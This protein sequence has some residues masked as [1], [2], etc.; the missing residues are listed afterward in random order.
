MKN[1]A[2][3]QAYRAV[4]E[5]EVE[6]DIPRLREAIADLQRR[7][8]DRLTRLLGRDFPEWRAQEGNRADRQ[9]IAQEMG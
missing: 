6:K 1:W 8:I 2:K 4:A 3:R 9:A 5:Q 7:Q